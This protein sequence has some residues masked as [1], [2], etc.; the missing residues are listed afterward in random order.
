MAKNVPWNYRSGA[1]QI[2][3]TGVHF[4][5]LFYFVG[6]YLTYYTVVV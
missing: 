6:I 5:S 4:L 1:L 2:D 3:S